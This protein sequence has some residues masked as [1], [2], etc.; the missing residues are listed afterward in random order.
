[1][2]W[3]SRF[4]QEIEAAMR[5]VPNDLPLADRIKAVDAARPAGGWYSASW[6]RKAWQA[7]RR[8]YL[9]RFG[10]VPKTK[11]AAQR[12]AAVVHDLPLFDD[13]IHEVP[14]DAS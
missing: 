3:R 12:A 4:A 6:P 14:S 11:K 1:M 5:N 13:A 9:V 2:S 8:D 10:Y 7:A